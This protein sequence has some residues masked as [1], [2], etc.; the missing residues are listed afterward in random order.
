MTLDEKIAHL[1]A[2]SMEEARAEG[3]SIIDSYRDALERVFQEHKE[4]MTRQSELRIKSENMNARQQLSQAA[5]KAQL[6]LKRQYSKIAQELKDKV[7]DEAGILV[8]E[9]M[10]T[11]EYVNFLVA[12]IRKALSF[13]N[14]EPV[15]IYINPTDEA[16]KD[17]LEAETGTS[18][19][20]SKE[21]FIGGTRCVIRGRNVLIDNSFK[22]QLRNEYDNF[23]FRGG[24]GIV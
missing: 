15:T 14:G 11:E 16:R 23:M 13:A 10:K 8:Q 19:T 4:E 17:A 1:Q 2:T 20:V 24:E 22:T 5:A 12:C 3:N 7:F 18:L 6:E 21:D 9:Y